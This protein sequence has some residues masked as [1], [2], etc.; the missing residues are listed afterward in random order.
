[1][2]RV[3][4]VFYHKPDIIKECFH[5]YN[6]LFSF[7]PHMLFDL[8]MFGAILKGLRNEISSKLAHKNWSIKKLNKQ[9]EG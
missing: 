8:F 7:S 3:D 6:V 9:I 5:R 2:L 4:L 1:M